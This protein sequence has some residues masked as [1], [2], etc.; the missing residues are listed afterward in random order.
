MARVAAFLE[1]H[2]WA[3]VTI[4][5]GAV[6]AVGLV[7]F[8]DYGIAWDEPVQRQYGRDVYQYI[9]KGDQE[10]FLNRH[11]YYG[12][13]FEL[14]L[15]SLEKAFRLGDT[16]AIYMMRHLV[17]FLIL[18]MGVVFFYLL[19]K[20]VFRSWRIGLLGSAFLVLSPRIFAHGFYNTK[21]IPFLSMFIMSVYTLL[22]YLDAKTLRRAA[23]HGAVCAVL[24]DT[25]IVGILLPALTAAFVGYEAIRG[26]VFA[27]GSGDESRGSA[28]KREG[29][30]DVHRRA[31][32]KRTA[33]S[34]LGYAMVWAAL[35]ILLWPTLW[36]DPLRNFVRV[37]EGMSN[38]P[39]EA[40]V[41]YLGKYVWATDLPW[42]YTPVWIAV[43]TPLAYVILFAI[44][45]FVCVKPLALRLAAARQ[46]PPGNT[47]KGDDS[48]LPRSGDGGS[49]QRDSLLILSWFF[50]P[51][52]Y[53]V[54]SKAVL[55]DEWRHSFFV[56]PA[57]LM[58]ALVGLMGVW[59]F[60]KMRFHGAGYRIASACLVWLIALNLGSTALFMLRHH[61][62]ENVFFNTLIGGP[63]GAHGKLEMDY[64]GLSYRKGLEYIARTNPKDRIPI[65]SAT[66]PGRYNADILKA[67]DRKRLTFVTDM[68]EAAYYI[69]N[70]RWEINRFPSESELYSVDVGG[71]KIMAVYDL[72][73]SAIHT[74]RLTQ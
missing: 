51:L 12:P 21:D 73:I 68:A 25:R 30:T 14:L 8:K 6:L 74:G 2:R 44:G 69:T 17:N 53:Y 20:R 50:L 42:H 63:K 26:V 9:T 40:S 35:T 64:W 7:A 59:N 18:W 23:V 15:Y 67:Q 61:P 66:L 34:F 52:I 28:I 31:E 55:Y 10:L 16:R 71:A 43:S 49:L 45:F 1:T 48:P 27:G 22:R 70:F 57:F 36:R 29:G 58:I 33:R 39:W 56:Y 3:A 5:L 32:V 38:F 54:P 62:F 11:R 47:Q 4:F 60:I 19:C 41:L 65:F 72:S 24:V 13:V 46:P 37:F